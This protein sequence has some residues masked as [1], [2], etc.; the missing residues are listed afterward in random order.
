MNSFV[1]ASWKN[2][3]IRVGIRQPSRRGRAFGLT[4]PLT[5]MSHAFVELL[6]IRKFPVASELTREIPRTQDP[7]EDALAVGHDYVVHSISHQQ[8]RRFILAHPRR[9][10]DDRLVRHRTAFTVE[11]DFLEPPLQGVSF[12][13]HL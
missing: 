7:G 10:H 3:E 4:D 11:R 5:R 9:R 6:P 2:L 8:R 12:R 13:N 1:G